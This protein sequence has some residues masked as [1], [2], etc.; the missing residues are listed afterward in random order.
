MKEKLG[1]FFVPLPPEE[2][3]ENPPVKA[4]GLYLTG[5]TAGGSRFR[6]LLALVEDTEL[7]AMVTT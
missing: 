2:G 1:P 4:K 3:K 5:N 7:N 6:E